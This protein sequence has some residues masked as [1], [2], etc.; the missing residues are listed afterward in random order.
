[1]SYTITGL[2][3]VP[4]LSARWCA[5]IRPILN[6]RWRVFVTER[7]F[8]TLMTAYQAGEIAAFDELYLR[9]Q[10]PLKRYLISLTMSVERAEDLVQETFL[11]IHRSRH[12]Y[13]P[14]RPVQPW[15]FGIARNVFLMDRR[16]GSRRQRHEADNV[17]E[18][19]ELPVPP[20]LDGFTH[21]DQLRRAVA[22]LPAEGREPLLLHHV[23]GFSY[24]EISGML[25]IRA[26]AAKVRAHRALEK[27]RTALGVDRAS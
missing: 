15:A 4:E 11:Q 21:R 25:G 1:M 10:P 8:S 24:K 2:P 19:P 12:T 9:L 23:W 5:S 14:P 26:G 6:N 16:A 18:L 20:A 17:D 13:V 7:D 27:L 3:D 22:G